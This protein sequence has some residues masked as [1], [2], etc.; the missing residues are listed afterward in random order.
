ASVSA[1]TYLA[2]SQEAGEQ[3]GVLMSNGT[4]GWMKKRDVNVLNY[5]V[6]ASTD[7][8][9]QQRTMLASRSGSALA[10]GASTAILQEAYRHLGVPYKYGG[11]P[12]SSGMDGS[13]FVQ[14]CFARVGGGLPRT[15]HEQAEVG[16]AV[17]L[18]EL[19]AGDRLYFAGRSGSISH[20][21]IYIGD[22]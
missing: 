4:I 17:S 11:T 19:Q 15:A 14:R 3:Y 8:L 21:G 13:A 7:Q 9:R 16:S 12:T 22:G 1:G 10:G 18:D 2:L 20:T 5:E 6:T